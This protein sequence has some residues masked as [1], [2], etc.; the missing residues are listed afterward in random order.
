MWDEQH[1]SLVPLFKIIA[2]LKAATSEL[3]FDSTT[4]TLAKCITVFIH[5]HSHKVKLESMIIRIY[6]VF[7]HIDSHK[8]KLESMIIH[9]KMWCHAKEVLLGCSCAAAPL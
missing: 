7:I 4:L 8:I 3:D 1:C 5:L 9:I 6:T 2:K